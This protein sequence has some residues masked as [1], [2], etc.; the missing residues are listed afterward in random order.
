[1]AIDKL[2]ISRSEAIVRVR[3]DIVGTPRLSFRTLT[4]QVSFRPA[5]TT[6]PIVW[7]NQP[8][9]SALFQ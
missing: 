3:R 9:T 8:R 5:V 7:V 4:L 1:M 6:S 2:P